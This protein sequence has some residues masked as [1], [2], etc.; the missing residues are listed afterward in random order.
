MVSVQA[1]CTLDEALALMGDRAVVNETTA[2]AI[3]IAV[4]GGWIRV[5]E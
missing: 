4:V 2:Y 3:A 5:G 1:S